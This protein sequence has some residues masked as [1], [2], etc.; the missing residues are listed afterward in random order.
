MS[1]FECDL[2]LAPTTDPSQN[3]DKRPKGVRPRA[4]FLLQAIENACSTPK[5]ERS[6]RQNRHS[7]SRLRI[8]FRLDER[9]VLPD[10]LLEDLTQ[11]R[12][13][14]DTQFLGQTM[15]GLLVQSQGVCLAP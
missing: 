10:H 1:E 9:A 6:V 11:V 12:G 5:A 8:D 2:A 3:P 14:I 7:G 13:W 15:P 4:K